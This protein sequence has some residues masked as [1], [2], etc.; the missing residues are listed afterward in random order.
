MTDKIKE[1][2]AQAR[3]ALAVDAMN[4]GEFNMQSY[5]EKFAELIVKECIKLAHSVSE[6]R[7]VNEDMIYGADS[8]AVLISK[9]FD[10][11]ISVPKEKEHER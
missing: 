6:L 8:V 3:K 7:G 5:E 1:L 2:A 10:V 9:H 4:G 11:K